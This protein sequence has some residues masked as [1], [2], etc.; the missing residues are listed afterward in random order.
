M[1]ERGKDSALEESFA[2][3]FLRSG[4][5]QTLLFNETPYYLFIIE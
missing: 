3:S 1:V 2:D 5:V 4:L